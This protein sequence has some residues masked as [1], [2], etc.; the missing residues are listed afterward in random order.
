MLQ[1]YNQA[2]SVWHAEDLIQSVYNW[3]N[4]RESRNWDRF[5]YEQPYFKNTWFQIEHPA[6][7]SGP[8]LKIM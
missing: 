3:N 7:L 4:E 1:A 8:P 6:F 5:E 2:N